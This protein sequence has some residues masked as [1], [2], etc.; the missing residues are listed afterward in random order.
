MVGNRSPG[1]FAIAFC[2]AASSRG[3]TSGRRSRIGGGG[4]LMCRIA[5][6]TKFSPGNGTSLVSSS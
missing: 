4:S 6:V 1:S 5:I 3:E 2:T